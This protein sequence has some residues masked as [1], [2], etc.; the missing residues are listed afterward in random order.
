MF[1][2]FGL[3]V[4]KF[5]LHGFDLFSL[6]IINLAVDFGGLHIGQMLV[7]SWWMLWF[8]GLL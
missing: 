6:W 2:G 4:M 8:S 7:V 3:C 5:C 1:G